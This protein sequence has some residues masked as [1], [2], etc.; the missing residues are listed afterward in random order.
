MAA[1]YD[2]VVRNGTIIDGSGGPAFDGDIAVANGVIAA[3]G[4]VNG[5][6][7]EEIDAEGKV[8]TPG[9][10]DIHTHYDGQITWDNSLAPSSHHGVTTV[11]MGNCGVGFAPCKPEDRELLMTLMEGIEDIPIDTMRSAIPWNWQSFPDFLSALEAK[12]CEVDFAAQVPHG[13]LRVFAMGKRAVDREPATTADV[14]LMARLVGEAVEAGALGFSTSRTLQHRTKSGALC[15]TITA[16]ED[17]LGAI[18]F[19]MGEAGKGVIEFA[20]DFHGASEQYSAEFEMWQRIGHRSGR[21][22]SYALIQFPATPDAWRHL[23]KFT[24]RANGDGIIIK[25]Q[26]STRGIG[27][28]YGLDTSEH[29]FTRTPSYRAISHLELDARVALMRR[30][31]V[32]ERIIAEAPTHPI[33]GNRII[34]N[35]FPFGDPPDYE[36]PRE[37]SVAARAERNGRS[38]FEEAYE[39]LLGTGGHSMLY[40]PAVNYAA[41]TLDVIYEMMSHPDTLIGIGDGGAHLGRVCDASIPTH[42]LTYWTRD[43]RG[44]RVPLA[45][46][47]RMITRDTARFYGLAD[48]G[49]IAPGMIGDLNVIDYDR[50]RLHAPV[51]HH[52]LPAGGTRLLQEADGYCVTVKSGAV[53]FREGTPTGELP[54]R[55]VRGARTAPVR[56]TAA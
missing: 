20:D 54:G 56:R 51:V 9:F 28:L 4:Q 50:L 55:L 8:V 47:V 52:D 1:Q 41:G 22:L 34:A 14:A 11:V 32:R 12:R 53:T 30:P 24:A 44:A 43:R 21:P 7:R 45:E 42:L 31:D 3:V 40:Y 39:L 36:P 38:V 26:V 16:S 19:A 6:G 46:A 35:M 13:A 48:R 15:P 27:S 29:P 17:E 37:Q 2:L 23:L 18:A 49:V 33:P 5:S 10:V 25:P